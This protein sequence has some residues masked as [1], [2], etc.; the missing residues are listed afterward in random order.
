MVYALY[1]RAGICLLQEFCRRIGIQATDDGIRQLTAALA[2]LPSGHPLQALMANTPDFR[3]EAALADALLNP[4]DRA[5]SV[6]QLFG[7]IQN[8]GMKFGRWV[9]QAPYS[10]HCGVIARIPLASQIAALST[11]EQYAAVELFRGTLIR[12]SV[13][14]YRNDSPYGSEQVSFSGDNWLDTVPIR[15][16]ETI[17]VQE[18]LPPGASAVL[19]NQG[20]TNPDLFMPIDSCE[21]RL[22]DAVDSDQ[23]IRDILRNTNM[24][25]QPPVREDVARIFFEKLWHHDQIVVTS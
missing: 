20:H 11:E 25:S 1:G 8:G 9:R 22:Y 5:Y 3:K 2:A 21:K 4:L 16:P 10:P 13:I 15:M 23:T 19:I 18:R 7:F 6:P 12:H 14:I 24:C 17:C